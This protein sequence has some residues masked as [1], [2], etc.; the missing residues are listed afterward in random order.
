[1]GRSKHS[2]G[3]WEDTPKRPTL[4]TGMAEKAAEAAEETKKTKEQRLKE[5][6]KELGM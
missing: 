2:G 5:I 3:E 6:E 4:G 1:M